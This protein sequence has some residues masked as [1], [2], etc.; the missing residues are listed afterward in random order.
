MRLT[1]KSARPHGGEQTRLT[2]RAHAVA[3]LALTPSVEQLVKVVE[4][5]LSSAVAL[6]SSGL[7]IVRS[8]ANPPTVV[9]TSSSEYVASVC[10]DEALEEFS[11]SA[12]IE[13]DII[14]AVL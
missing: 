12:D 11:S 14:T 7:S 5:V 1:I 2:P 8:H 6:P 4:V 3:D 13:V 10:V 9:T